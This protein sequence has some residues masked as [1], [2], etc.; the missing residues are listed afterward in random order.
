[1]VEFFTMWPRYCS[2]VRLNALFLCFALSLCSRSLV[3]TQHKCSAWSCLFL[4]K[5]SISSRYTVAKTSSFSART[6]SMSR[7]KVAGA[8]TSP[9]GSTVY[10]YKPHRDWKAV[11]CQSL[12]ATLTWWYAYMRS[13]LEYT[14]EPPSLS[15][16]SSMMGYRV[17]VDD[18]IRVQGSKVN[19]H[20]KFPTFLR[21]KQYRV[22]ILRVT[23][24]NPTFGQQ[25]IDFFLC[26]F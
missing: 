23:G 25:F 1:M 13:I 5:T 19:A 9:N 8:L 18:C 10:S 7:W 16:I 2:S 17:S 24:L 11:W 3:S 22:I 21:H 4:E 6:W 12:S 15:N 20:A 26:F 14:M